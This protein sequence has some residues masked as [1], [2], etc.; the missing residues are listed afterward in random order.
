[1]SQVKLPDG[2]VKS[3]P[4]QVC[5]TVGDAGSEREAA[6]RWFSH[7]N[8][9]M[10]HYS[11]DHEDF[12]DL[13]RP[14]SQ[15]PYTPEPGYVLIVPEADSC[16]SVGITSSAFRSLGIKA[17]QFLSPREGYRTGA[18]EI[19]GEWYYH[20]GNTSLAQEVL[21]LCV[22]LVQTLEEIEDA[23]YGPSCE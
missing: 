3:L 10:T 1:M 13:Y 17:E 19:G 16:S 7:L 2:T 4:T 9:V 22:F 5:E 11:G 12:A 18:V 6:E 20:D 8:E 21:P 15:T 14:Y 23:W